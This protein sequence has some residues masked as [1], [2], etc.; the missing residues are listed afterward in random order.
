MQHTPFPEALQAVRD[1]DPAAEVVV[2]APSE[3][4]LALLRQTATDAGGYLRVHGYTAAR[5]VDALAAPELARAGL[6]APPPMWLEAVLVD[7]A[8]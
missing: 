6:R 5:L 2:L 3:A 1:A 8:A 7:A 4:A